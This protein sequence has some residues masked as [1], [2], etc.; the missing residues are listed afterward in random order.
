MPRHFLLAALFLALLC[1]CADRIARADDTT[2]VCYSGTCLTITTKG[3]GSWAYSQTRPGSKDEGSCTFAVV[4]YTNAGA[5]IPRSGFVQATITVDSTSELIS[6]PNPEYPDNSDQRYILVPGIDALTM[7]LLQ[8][9]SGGVHYSGSRT[10]SFIRAGE[11]RS[12]SIGYTMSQDYGDYATL[13]IGTGWSGCWEVYVSSP[14]DFSGPENKDENLGA[15][16]DNPDTEFERGGAGTCSGQGLPV[17]GVNMS[18]LSLAV[19][20]TDLAY[21][22]FGHQVE[23]RRVWNMRPSETGLFGNGW[24]FAYASTLTA[25]SHTSGGAVVKLGNGQG[26]SYTVS[27]TTGQGTGELTVSY[28]CSAKGRTQQLTGVLNEATGTGHYILHDKQAKLTRR[29][30]YVAQDG[31]G[32]Y[33]YRLTS[34]TDR[35]GNALTLTYDGKG[36][37][38]TLMDAS[39]RVTTF[40]TD[41]SGRC[42]QFTTLGGRT[43]F[44]QYDADGN[45]TKSTDL[46]GNVTTY[47]YTADKYIAS[48]TTAGRT[49][50]FTYSTSGQTTY[51]SQVTDA[52]GAVWQYGYVSPAIKTVTEPGGAVRTYSNSGGRTTQITN[53]LGQTT[54]RS[55]TAQGMLA[56]ETDATGRAASFEYDGDGNPTKW[57][58]ADG[59]ATTFTYDANGNMTGK[60]DPMGNSWTYGYDVRGNLTSITSPLARST[61]MAYDS[62]GL[63]TSATLPGGASQSYQYDTHGNLTDIFDPLGN[64]TRI[65]YDTAG[66]NRASLTDPAGNTTSFMYDDNRRL[67]MQTHPGGATNQYGYDCCAMT[68]SID[69]NGRTTLYARDALMN[70]TRITD[71]MGGQTQFTYNANSSPLTEVN[72]LGRIR[73]YTYD[74]ANRLFSDTDPAGRTVFYGRDAAGRVTSVMN[75]KGAATTQEYGL[76]GQLLNVFDPQGNNTANYTINAAGRIVAKYNGR[77]QLYM[78]TYDADGRVVTKKHENAVAASY[79]WDQQG[80][81]TSHSTPATGTVNWTRDA[82]G[83][84]TMTQDPDGAK[85]LN[86][87][88]DSAGRVSGIGYPGG[89][90]VTYTRNGRGWPTKVDFG[91]Y[92]VSL[93]YDGEGRVTSETRSNGMNTT[94]GY[95]ATGKLTSVAH[96]SASRTLANISYARDASGAIVSESGTWPLTPRGPVKPFRATFNNADSMTAW[97]TDPA[98]ADADG[99]L[100]AIAGTRAMTAVYDVENR[101][102]S[103]V[104]GGVTRQYRYDALGN[105]VWV[106]AGGV[107]RN[108]H[109][110]PRG[111]AAFETDHTGA[112]TACYIYD[113]NRLLAS[114]TAAGGFVFHHYDKTGNTLALTDASG[115]TVGAYAYGPYGAVVAHTGRS[116]PFTYAGAY[117]VM[118]EGADFF[119]MRN[120]YYD[121]QAGRFLQRDPIG[122][123]GGI[124]L[125][126]Y[127]EGNP[128]R[129]IDPL[130]LRSD[131]GIFKGDYE[132]MSQNGK[133]VFEPNAYQRQM[134]DDFKTAADVTL[135]S[136]GGIVSAVYLPYK[137]MYI[138][139]TAPP[140]QRF[141]EGMFE[142]GKA[143][144]GGV[145][146]V[147]ADIFTAGQDTNMKRVKETEDEWRRTQ[148]FWCPKR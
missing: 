107:T 51:V 19:D 128:V 25:L 13:K 31:T 2:S 3:F 141:A 93:G 112:V 129:F 101:P 39:G 92:S 14:V 62:K 74:S 59:G 45:M 67:V 76:R 73:Q 64:R 56:S 119:L 75:P 134:W 143:L 21:Q 70:V 103:L 121:A 38:G 37:L 98:T 146:G 80:R 127:A 44:F 43:A 53:A 17:F 68:S 142:M 102:V 85:G 32:A 122:F 57:T 137:L 77:S 94:Y 148:Q 100:T 42:T 52:N 22:S 133:M 16:K 27:G 18:Y 91:A 28:A 120:R 46:A 138:N 26:F 40:V 41:V 47:T 104:A 65:A 136:K 110:D 86:I 36:S 71:P 116:T 60:V 84:V 113:D 5:S 147:M 61:S 82:A 23:L 29:Y 35:N 140:S 7:D 109:F 88:Y 130:G 24:S 87:S 79:A 49:T 118:D 114:G 78:L 69:A 10:F 145:Y 106:A 111:R 90:S 9:Y 95:N 58:E 97:G 81:L 8:S 117:G 11:S 1:P 83:Q 15:G 72:P 144:L 66:L 105:R 131:E 48:I 135:S 96:Q 108:L 63:Q 6:V 55:Y 132:H 126:R 139:Q 124:N 50:A 33:V 30:D 125:Y 34:I 4:E 123:E 99:N 115:A 20:D 12:G 54:Y 89:L